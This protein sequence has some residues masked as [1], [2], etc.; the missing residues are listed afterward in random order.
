[1]YIKS[2][3]HVQSCYFVNHAQPIGFLPFSL[4]SPSSLLKLPIISLCSV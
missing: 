2:V 4:P 1:M 3:M